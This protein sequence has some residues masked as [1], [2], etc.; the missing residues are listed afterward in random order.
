MRERVHAT[1]QQTTVEGEAR[2]FIIAN[3]LM[4]GPRVNVNL[5]LGFMLIMDADGNFTTRVNFL[6]VSCVGGG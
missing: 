2:S 3:G 1:S 5:H 4:I 6:H